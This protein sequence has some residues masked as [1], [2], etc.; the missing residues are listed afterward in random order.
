M[1]H[2]IVF[3]SHKYPAKSDRLENASNCFHHNMCGKKYAHIIGRRSFA[4]EPQA[5]ILSCV[6]LYPKNRAPVSGT[7][8]H[9]SV[10]KARI[11][12]SVRW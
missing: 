2:I 9:H 10:I 6:W 1:H 8:T 5:I 12:V 4:S 7:L 3:E 11:T